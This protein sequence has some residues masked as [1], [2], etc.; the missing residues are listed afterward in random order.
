MIRGI[1]QSSYFDRGSSRAYKQ[2]PADVQA[3]MKEELDL[4]DEVCNGE[5]KGLEIKSLC[6]A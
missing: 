1:G 6:K 3:K 4:H 5:W 2:A